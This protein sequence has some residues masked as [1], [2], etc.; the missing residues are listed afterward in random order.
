MVFVGSLGVKKMRRWWKA[1]VVPYRTLSVVKL[2]NPASSI[3]S[4]IIS[5]G[6]WVCLLFVRADVDEIE[7]KIGNMH[8]K[9][10]VQSQPTVLE[11]YHEE[12]VKK[13]DFSARAQNGRCTSCFGSVTFGCLKFHSSRHVHS[14]KFLF[15]NQ[16]QR[17]RADRRD[18]Q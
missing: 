18:P 10:V 4:C 15:P 12:D 13:K 7:R 6:C 11:Y 14:K 16:D 2:P 1:E 3:V 17:A 5:T 9:Y 8:D